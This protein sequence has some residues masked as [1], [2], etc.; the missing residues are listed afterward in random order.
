MRSIVT[1]CASSLLLLGGAGAAQAPAPPHHCIVIRDQHGGTTWRSDA[2]ACATRLAPA[3]TFKI[4]HALVALETGV[5]KPDTVDKWDGTK[6]PNYPLWQRDHTVVS[7]MRPSVVWFFQRIAP[8]IGAARMHD[9]LTK[10]HYGN[11]S[12]AG[13]VTTYWLNG[14]L[15]VSPEEQVAF[16]QMLHGDRPPF[17]RERIDL[18]LD[19]LAQPAAAVENASGVTRLEVAKDAWPK[20]AAWR[21]KTGRTQFDGRRVNWLIGDLTVGKRSYLFASA[22]WRDGADIDAVDAAQRALNTFVERGLLEELKI[23]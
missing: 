14:T 11:A 4:P 19:A 6:Y 7:A 12:T 17:A 18:I 22:V 3:S 9:W 8:R 5:V 20:D 21:A 2:S 15:R 10:L 23:R 1:L 13:D 16:L